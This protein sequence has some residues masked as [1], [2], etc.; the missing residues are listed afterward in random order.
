MASGKKNY[1]RHSFFTRNDI[2]MLMLRDRVGVGF[3]FYF[4]SLLELCGEESS[5]QLKHQ[6]TFHD[7]TIR[8]L[9]CVNLK[10]SER[11]AYEMDAVGLLEFKKGEKNFQFTIPNFAKYLGKYTTKNT[12]NSS[13]KRKEKESKRKESKVNSESTFTPDELIQLWN[14]MLTPYGFDHCRGI[15]T[16]KFLSDFLEARQWLKTSESWGELFD[17]VIQSEYL[18]GENINGWKASLTWLVDYDNALK[19]LNG[20][21]ANKE[22]QNVLSDSFIEKL[23]QENGQ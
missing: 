8:S 20:N 22:K 1:F 9:W 11:I 18:K 15:G 2:K 12:S 14:T 19:V 17:A 16:G 3:Y 6:Y 7:S 10:K 5:D 4:F 13:N 23:N 21:Y